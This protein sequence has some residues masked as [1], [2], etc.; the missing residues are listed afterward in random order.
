M[1]I[2]HETVN[3]NE[4][5]GLGTREILLK[6]FFFRYQGKLYVYTSSVAEQTLL[7]NSSEDEIHEEKISED[8]DKLII[9]F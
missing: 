2:L 4:I 9:V 7:A 3:N 8:E 1:I 5:V 6:R